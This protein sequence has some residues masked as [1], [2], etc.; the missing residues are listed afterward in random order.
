MID[1]GGAGPAIVGDTIAG[2]TIFAPATGR[3]RAGIAVV[4]ISGPGAGPALARLTGRDEWPPRRA[5]RADMADPKTGDLIDRGL[6]IWFPGPASFTGEDVVELHTHGGPAVSDGI[7]AALAGISGLRPAE[8]GE[9]S[10]RAF[11]NGKLDLTEAEAIADLVAAE[12]AAQRRQA[13]NQLDGSL[14]RL[15]GDWSGRLTRNL[16]YLE[17]DL[18]FADEDLPDDLATAAAAELETLAA[19]IARH[20]DDGRRGERLRDGITIAIIGPPNA[21]KSSLLNALA[22]RDVAIVSERAGTTRDVLEVHLDLGGYP[23]VVLDTAGLREAADAVEAEGVRRARARAT[24]ADIK[25]LLLSQDAPATPAL[26]DLLGPDDLTIWNKA[27]RA[28]RPG[29]AGSGATGGRPD[30][31]I[32]ALRGDGLAALVDRLARLAGD[33]LAGGTGPALTRVRHRSALEEALT[34]LRRASTA[35]LPELRAEDIRLAI[36]A[37]GRITGRVDVEDL[38]DVIFRDFCIGK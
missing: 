32:S 1:P 38:L 34:A 19:E 8:P 37:L 3:G 22:Q 2:G 6:A 14:G 28:D 36:R 23:A 24:A 17:A 7:A 31:M 11:E 5:S 16:A 12:T 33:R 25:L 9:F 35:A 18:D 20:L 27:D 30:V 15:Y 21:G 10:R 4:R 29:A 26:L 13:L